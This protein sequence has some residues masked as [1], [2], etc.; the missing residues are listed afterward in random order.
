MISLPLPNSNHP[1][2]PIEF[3]TVQTFEFK[4]DFELFKAICERNMTGDVSSQSMLE[5]GVGYSMTRFTTGD[6]VVTRPS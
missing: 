2:W 5:Y 4:L 1:L 6:Y 3:L